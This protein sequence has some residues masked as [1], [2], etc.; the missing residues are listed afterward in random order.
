M[1]KVNE[2]K[3]N[4]TVGV[5]INRASVADGPEGVSTSNTIRRNDIHDNGFIFQTGIPVI[6]GS[7]ISV[8]GTSLLAIERNNIFNPLRV[9]S[10]P[11]AA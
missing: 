11:L 9:Y 6:P 5:R 4:K 2:I 3:N 7:G 8:S 1:T 10:P